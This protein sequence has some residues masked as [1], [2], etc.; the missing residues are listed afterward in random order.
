MSRI[1]VIVA[2]FNICGKSESTYYA[3]ENV[4]HISPFGYMYAYVLVS[5]QEIGRLLIFWFIRSCMSWQ[6]YYYKILTQWVWFSMSR[7]NFIG[8]GQNSAHPL[9][10]NRWIARSAITQGSLMCV[11]AVYSVMSLRKRNS[12]KWRM[13]RNDLVSWIEALIFIMG[14]IIQMAQMKWCRPNNIFDK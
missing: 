3:C 5:M 4:R 1:D 13:P 10:D 6:L 8:S 11:N 7:R 2:T 9:L 14:R 12:C